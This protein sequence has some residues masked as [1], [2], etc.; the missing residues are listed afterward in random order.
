MTTARY[1]GA[2]WIRSALGRELSPLGAAVADL[3]GDVFA[4]IYHLDNAD[5][6]KVDW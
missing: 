3:L 1:A 2:A 5:L 4:G 6:R